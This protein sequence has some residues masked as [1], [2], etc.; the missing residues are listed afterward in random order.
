LDAPG[1]LHYVTA[2]GIDH[3]MIFR[4]ETDRRALLIEYAAPGATA[5]PQC[6]RGAFRQ[7]TSP[8]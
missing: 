5:A 7:T 1:A 2:R 8:S 6:T 4:A 3:G